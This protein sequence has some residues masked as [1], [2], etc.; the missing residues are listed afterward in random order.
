MHSLRSHASRNAFD[1]S[2]LLVLT[3]IVIVFA[4]ALAY[5]HANGNLLLAGLAGLGILAAGVMTALVSRG[6]LG[7]RLTLPIIGMAMV[8]LSIQ[9]AHGR[10]EAH[11]GVFA[12][13]SLLLVY[14]DWRAIVSG[15]AAIAIHHLSFDALQS[16][17]WGTI[18]FSEPGFLRVVEHA[19]FVVAQAACLC[20]LALRSDREARAGTEASTLV[21]GFVD[22]T[23]RIDLGVARQGVH[24]QVGQQFALALERLRE[25]LAVVHDAAG[26][27][28]K[29]A[30]EIS[31]GNDDLARRTEQQAL[32]LQQ[33][34]NRVT[35]LNG[36]IRENAQ[37]GTQADALASDLSARARRAGALVGDVV[38]TMH[39]IE[40]GS[41]RIADI[42]GVIDGIAFQTNIL[43]LN[44]AVE[45]ARAGDQ[46]RGFAVV[47]SEVRT[48]AQRSAQ[49]AREI[50]DLIESSVRS[51]A[52][53]SRLV[54]DSGK[55]MREVV[56]GVQG[57]AELIGRISHATGEQSDGMTDVD[58]AVTEIDRMTSQ[59]AALVEQAAAAA[60][61]LTLQSERMLEAVSSFTG[62]RA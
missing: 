42:I 60:K 62:S 45:A 7:A 39:T 33:A 23:G 55:A 44:A 6:G 14:R 34:V 41:R 1:L 19:V 37:T 16:A 56:D 38:N 58:R 17:G 57:V 47:A 27:V 21:A 36:T 29:A 32:Q 25:S 30:N 24:T 5:G 13:L 11:F 2:D 12:F 8:A 52:D 31:Q 28:A 54:D 48:L 10:I 9:V 51:V 53:G 49:A 3:G 59:N 35:Q 50:K 22:H 40:A 18:C 61:S 15:A 4:G 20:W 43:A 46:G 26:S